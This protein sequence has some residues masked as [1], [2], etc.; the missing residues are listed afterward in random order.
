MQHPSLPIDVLSAEPEQ[1]AT[2]VIVL[3]VLWPH[4]LQ[5]EGLGELVSHFLAGLLVESVKNWKMSL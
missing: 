4:L 1:L 5:R 2:I 3:D